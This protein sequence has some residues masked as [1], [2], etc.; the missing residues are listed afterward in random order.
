MGL[1]TVTFIT[2]SLICLIHSYVQ[3]GSK[4]TQSKYPPFLPTDLPRTTFLRLEWNLSTERFIM[5]GE[6]AWRLFTGEM[7]PYADLLVTHW[8]RMG[9]KVSEKIP[10]LKPL[11]LLKK[12]PFP[13]PFFWCVLWAANSS[14]SSQV[15]FPLYSTRLLLC[16]CLR[17]EC[18]P[19]G[20][21][22]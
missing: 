11:A 18:C 4:H 8:T 14:T 10:L 6:R 5:E 13:I 16:H 19:Y 3:S 7:A 22:F 17:G 1:L 9:K 12:L 20:F 15:S 2:F 21:K